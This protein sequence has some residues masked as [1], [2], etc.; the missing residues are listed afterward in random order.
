M[1]PNKKGIRRLAIVLLT[2]V[3]LM[4]CC[5]L[6][7]TNASGTELYSEEEVLIL[8]KTVFGE[9][10]GL[11]KYE[12][13]MVI[14]CILNRFDH[15]GFGKTL[16]EIITKPYQFQ[17]YL[18]N[19]PIDEEILRLCKDVLTRWKYGLE[20]RTLPKEYLFFHGD[21]KHNYFTTE[22]QGGETYDF[23]LP[24]PY[25]ERVILFKEGTKMENF[26]PEQLT[27]MAKT[28]IGSIAEITAIYAERLDQTELDPMTK[29]A[30]AIGF[31][32]SFMKI[33]LGGREK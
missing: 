28:V 23:S 17:G 13:S 15:G 31:Q 16:T 33:A 12:Q 4:L 32:E 7:I 9:A 26:T 25:S 2:V 3:F 21:G 22:Y 20:G 19:N 30:L 18:V 27:E 1:R 29:L 10:G 14:W 6:V 11:G 5:A 8:A 24:D